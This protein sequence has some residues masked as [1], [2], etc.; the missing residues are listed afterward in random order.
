MSLWFMLKVIVPRHRLI[1][2]Y[3]FLFLITDLMHH[4]E[5]MLSDPNQT[6]PQCYVTN[7]C[8]LGRVKM[9][10]KDPPAVALL[11][12][13]IPA[14]TAERSFSSKVSDNFEE[15]SGPERPSGLVIFC[16]ENEWAEKLNPEQVVEDF[17]VHK[18]HAKP[19]RRV[20]IQQQTHCWM[21]L[22]HQMRTTTALPRNAALRVLRY[23]V[24][25]NGLFSACVCSDMRRHN[26]TDSKCIL[27]IEGMQSR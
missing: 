11:F 18:A 7:R 14:V 13:T 10:T 24:C 19:F 12:V 8:M 27:L 16:F 4:P 26:H 22:S 17:T 21:E 2:G 20:S 1:K 25:K 3:I 5:N 23:V 9:L 15:H 6:H